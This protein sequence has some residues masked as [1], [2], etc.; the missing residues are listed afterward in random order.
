M[1]MTFFNRMHI[2]KRYVFLLGVF[3]TLFSYALSLSAQTSEVKMIN[4]A[5]FKQ[6]VWNYDKS[7]S[8]RLESR[9]PVIVD[10]FATWCP[11]CKRMS[12]LIDQLQ[13]ELR[14]KV[15]IYRVDVDKDQVLAQRMGIEAMP[16]LIFFSKKNTKF[17]SVGYMG[18]EEL[19]QTAI[20]KL[21]LR[22]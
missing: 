13:H 15:L 19:K 4:A 11:P 7:S 16:T 5:Q 3:L 18:Y 22:R 12:P 14:G 1:K 17:P 2:M 20:T 6:L 21:S 9:L 10:F 8:V